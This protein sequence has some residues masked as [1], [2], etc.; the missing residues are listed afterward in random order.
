MSRKFPHALANPLF[1]ILHAFRVV[2]K[3]YVLLPRKPDQYQKIMLGREIQ[4]PARWHRINAYRFHS[5]RDHPLEVATYNLRRLILGTIRLEPEGPIGDS[6][7]VEFPL[8]FPKKLP[9]NGWANGQT[10]EI[11]QT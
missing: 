8:T 5:G 3:R 10:G 2:E 6:A 9:P 4:Q 11:L 7:E 1:D